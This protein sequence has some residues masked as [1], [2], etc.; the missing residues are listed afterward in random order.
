MCFIGISQ[1]LLSQQLLEDAPTAHPPNRTKLRL[2]VNDTQSHAH[3]LQCRDSHARFFYRAL[4]CFLLDFWD[5][6]EC[7]ATLDSE[8]NAQLAN[9][10]AA[11]G[12]AYCFHLLGPA[13]GR[14]CMVHVVL[15]TSLVENP[16]VQIELVFTCFCAC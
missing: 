8:A 4:Q 11:P 16:Q 12:G 14:V 6:Q 7:Q 5:Q 13:S 1:L 2:Q 3:A 15:G 10:P 9:M